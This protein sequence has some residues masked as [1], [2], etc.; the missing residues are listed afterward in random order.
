MKTFKK[1]TLLLLSFALFLLCWGCEK[2]EPQESSVE[3]AQSREEKND[4]SVTFASEGGFPFSKLLVY[5]YEEGNSDYLVWAGETDD[6]GR[7]S[8]KA[9][10][11]KKYNAVIKNLP[12]G[13]EAKENYP[14]DR[15]NTQL[16]FK[17]V[18]SPVD[19]LSAV[20]YK[21]GSVAGDFKITDCNGTEYQISK[22]LETKK[23]IV[24]N[25]WFLNC[26][27]CRMEF[28]FLQQAY[29][30]HKDDIQVI[31]LN[32]Y[33]GTDKTVS[34][35]ASELGLTFPVASCD[36]DWQ[37]AMNLTAYPTTV[38]IDRYGTIAM[39]HKGSVTDKETFVKVFEFF[40]SDNYKQTTIKNLSEIQ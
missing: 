29:E 32:P 34:Q 13:Y 20:K 23:A 12:E 25:F 11:S 37:T 18:L 15:E 10:P 3:E 33:D 24:L 1:F 9:D 28:P 8:F 19:D 35:Y 16:V 6:M 30:D 36:A 4:F 39:V 26:Q 7:V 40:A 17:T 27:P 2:Q 14:L 31:A 21:L 22:L 5:I 38:V